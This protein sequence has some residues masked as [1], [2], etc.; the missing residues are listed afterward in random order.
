MH[1]MRTYIISYLTH[2]APLNFVINSLFRQRSVAYWS[3]KPLPE[4]MVEH[5]LLD[6]YTNFGDIWIKPNIRFIKKMCF[7]MS[8]A[9]WRL[10][11]SGF[12]ML[13][14]QPG[15]LEPGVIS[16]IHLSYAL[17]A[18]SD[19]IPIALRHLMDR[20]KYWMSGINSDQIWWFFCLGQ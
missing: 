10:S 8:S 3:V 4:P 16:V 19:S 9:N 20:K 15:V 5:S 1:F 7:E 11:Y 2:F 6:P 12:N 14:I 17:S 18:D 13:K